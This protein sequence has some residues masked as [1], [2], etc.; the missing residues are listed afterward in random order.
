MHHIVLLVIVKTKWLI[1]L[2]FFT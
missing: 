1:G 2:G